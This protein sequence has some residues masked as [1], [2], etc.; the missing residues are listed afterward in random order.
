MRWN[1]QHIIDRS[2]AELSGV[3]MWCC[4]TRFPFSVRPFRMASLL[5]FNKVR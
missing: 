4:E 1:G 5:E 3:T 2:E